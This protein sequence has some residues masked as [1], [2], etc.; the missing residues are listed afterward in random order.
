MKFMFVG[1]AVGVRKDR[2]KFI[3]RLLIAANDIPYG[4]S[5]RERLGWHQ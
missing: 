1:V 4:E 5:Q 2:W 3:A